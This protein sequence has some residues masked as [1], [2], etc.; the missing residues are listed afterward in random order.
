MPQ[1]AGLENY[2]AIER[3]SID[4][5]VS[6]IN[7]G[8]RGRFEKELYRAKALD[9][10][11][12]VVETVLSDLVKGK[13]ES[14]MLPQSVIQSILA[15]AIRYRLPIFFCEN[16]AYGQWVIESLLAKYVREMDKK[17]AGIKKAN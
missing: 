5:R 12:M 10:F 17:L 7:N 15:F 3:K 16:R 8:N 6:W 13:Y 9:Y 11:A 14:A 1:I 2:I 4:D